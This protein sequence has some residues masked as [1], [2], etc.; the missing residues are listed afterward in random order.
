MTRP[1]CPCCPTPIDPR[2]DI[3]EA[4]RDH[5]EQAE[6]AGNYFVATTWRQAAAIAAGFV[7]KPGTGP[8]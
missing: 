1:K 7:V 8:R 2:P 4:F 6:R 5:A 3:A